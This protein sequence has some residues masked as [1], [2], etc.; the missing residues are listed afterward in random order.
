MIADV[1]DKEIKEVFRTSIIQQTSYWSEVKKMQGV[2]SKAYNF[3]VKK[4]RPLF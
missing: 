4:I 2:E 1:E 3:K